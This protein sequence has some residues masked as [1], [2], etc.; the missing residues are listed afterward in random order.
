MSAAAELQRSSGAVRLSFKRVGHNTVLDSLYQDGCYKARLPGREHRLAAEAVLINTS[1]GM[2]DGDVLET[3]VVWAENTTALV[4]TQAAERIYRSRRD[5]AIIENRLVLAERATACWLPQETIVFDGA[6]LERINDIHMTS[7]SRLFA[8]EIVVFGR[9]AMG[10]V[11]RTGRLFDQWRVRVD[12]RLVF[13]DS[14]RFD[15]RRDDS[16]DNRL[17]RNAVADGRTV[18]ATIA[19]AGADCADHLAV[20][21]DVLEDGD[22]LAGASNLGPLVIARMLARDSKSVR[23]VVA[24]VLK[25]LGNKHADGPLSAFAL[26]RVWNC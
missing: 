17:A 1:G 9:A 25:T 12:G 11:V 7:G 22:A 14:T 26:P 5:P 15:N 8:A 18:M 24:R 13:A 21:R 3:E 10:E 4:T 19:Y 2:T 23:D 20:L 16:I 6:C